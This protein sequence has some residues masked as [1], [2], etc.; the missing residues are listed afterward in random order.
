MVDV[1][2]NPRFME[3]A[4]ASIDGHVRTFRY[5]AVKN[6]NKTRQNGGGGASEK[7]N[8]IKLSQEEVQIQEQE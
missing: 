4:S 5:P 2:V 1:A 8:A 3:W 7:V 6:K